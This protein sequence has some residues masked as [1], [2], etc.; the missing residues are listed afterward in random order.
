MPVNAPQQLPAF[1]L[2]TFSCF[3]VFKFKLLIN[4]CASIYV[5]SS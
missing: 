3:H 2:L 4:N 1:V 5:N